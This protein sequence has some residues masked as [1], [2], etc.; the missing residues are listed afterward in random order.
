MSKVDYQD[1]I[2]YEEKAIELIGG[3]EAWTIM[4]DPRY[5]LILVALRKGP[6]TV[7]DLE[8]EYN[9]LVLKNIETLSLQPKDKKELVEKTKR[10]GKT[11]YKYLTL[12][13]KAGLV[14]QA[15]KRIKM[16]QTATET[17]YGRS[18]KLF[19]QSDKA[20]LHKHTK[21]VKKIIP[22]LCKI[23]SLEFGG[24]EISEECLEKFVEDLFLTIHDNREEIFSKYSDVIT[25]ESSEIYFDDLNLVVEIL[26]MYMT[27]K[28]A[29][30]FSKQLEKC[31]K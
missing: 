30:K 10:K 21:A 7:K 13:E 14:V 24:K 20:D 31:L 5:E 25:Q 2:T 3:K 16:G 22:I 17:L 26:H 23:F 12:L 11:L 9:N 29:P 28:N 27:I 4:G 6:M 19:F 15:G 1:F 8:I 18:A